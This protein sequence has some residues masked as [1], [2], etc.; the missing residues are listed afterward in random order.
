MAPNKYNMK[1]TIAAVLATLP[2]LRTPSTKL[3]VKEL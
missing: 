1:N 3:A 2:Y